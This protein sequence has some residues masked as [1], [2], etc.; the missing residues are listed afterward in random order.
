MSFFFIIFMVI[1]MKVYIDLVILLN[2]YLD[3]LLLLTTSIVLKRKTSLKRIFL[4]SLVGSSTTFFLF[5]SISN[6]LLF[7]LKIGIALLMVITTFR[8]INYKYTLSNFLYFYM[9]SIILG[10]F[11][12]YLNIE[13]NYTKL[14]LL[15]L[16]HNLNGNVIFLPV[17]SPI[18][19][20]FYIKQQRKL[21]TTYQLS[22]KIKI[23][24]K[25]Q[26]EYQLNAF[27]DT[28]NR[29]VD[30]ITN[31]PI[32]LLEKGILEEKNLPFYYIPFQ[33]LNNKNLLKCIKPLYIEIENKKYKSYLV[34]I[35]DKKFHLEGVSCI[36][37]YKLMEE[38]I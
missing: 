12:Y 16:E 24:L 7:L 38:L 3:F 34:G 25:N 37:N 6:F 23:V 22:Y 29:L 14:G 27:L 8:Y 15:L 35:S 30:P 11:L 9:I 32:I 4:G 10:G 36:L 19:L 2:L 20:F 28:G 18:I 17:C 21:K 33:S 13:F 5:F 1:K 31:K 26:K